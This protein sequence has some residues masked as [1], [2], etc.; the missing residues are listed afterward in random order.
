MARVTAVLPAGAE[1][2]V[3]LEHASIPGGPVEVW[4]VAD[5]DGTGHGRELECRED[6]NAASALV[7]MECSSAGCFDVHLS[8]YNLF[9]RGDYTGG[10]DVVGKVAAGG[11]ITMEDFAVG[12]G[13]LD[14]E[15]ANTLVAGGNLSLARGVVWGDAIHGGTYTGDS[16]VHFERGALSS[17]TPIDFEVRFAGLRNL[18]AQLAS[19]PVNGTTMLEEWGGITMQGTDPDVNVFD[20]QAS[21][22]SGAALLS[23]TAPAGSFVV[24][25]IHGTSATFSSFGHEFHG[26]IDQHGIL[27]NFVDAASIS[28]DGYGFW[29]TVL[30]PYADVTFNNGSWD[31]GLYARSLTGNAE[32]HINPLNDRTICQ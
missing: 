18:S 4:A 8:D 15:I 26:G 32:G 1:T 2:F 22:F 16:T 31:G 14:S 12:S 30:A 20:V 3:T 23:I 24:V 29:G 10:H 9:L 13:L 28:A 11:N 17:G 7:S 25:N 6:N 21:A 19:L 27:Y 5:D